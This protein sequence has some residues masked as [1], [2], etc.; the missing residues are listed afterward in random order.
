MNWT[1]Q[2]IPM[3]RFIVACWYGEQVNIY[4]GLILFAG[5]SVSSPGA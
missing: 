4:F 1:K 5:L 2:L 3:I